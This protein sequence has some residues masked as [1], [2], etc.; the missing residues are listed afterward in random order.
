LLARV[1]PGRALTMSPAALRRLA[2]HAFPGNVRELRNVLERAA[3][4]N[5]GPVIG[6]ASIEQALAV[7][8]SR[9]AFP[10][11]SV[12]QAVSHLPAGRRTP[13]REAEQQALRSALAAHAGNREALARSLGISLRTLYRKLRA[14]GPAAPE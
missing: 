9:A 10:A 5:D 6:L 2:R 12:A 14:L 11:P 4:L 13:L 3:L 8:V 1:A 7:G